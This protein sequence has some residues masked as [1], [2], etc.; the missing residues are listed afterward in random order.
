[1]MKPLL[2]KLALGAGGLAL[3]LS[4]GAGM[5]SA[6]PNLD[7]IVNSTC[8]YPQV[9]SALNAQSPQTARVL[10]SAPQVQA[11]LQDFLAAPRDQRLVMA[12]QIQSNPGGLGP[13][14]GVIQNVFSVCNNY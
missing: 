8:T 12:Q 1:M 6:D 14:L 3:A 4:A 2:V 7:P 10:N 13:Y 5:A 9:I 11:G